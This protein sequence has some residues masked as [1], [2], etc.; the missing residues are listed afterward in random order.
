MTII[1]NKADLK[2]K[3]FMNMINEMALIKKSILFINISSSSANMT[4]DIIKKTLNADLFTVDSFCDALNASTCIQFDMILI[5][6]SKP[7]M[8]TIEFLQK[9]S[10][11][12]KKRIPVLLMN[13]EAP[14][15]LEQGY[16]N[17]SYTDVIEKPFAIDNFISKL[18]Q[19]LH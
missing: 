8:E 2:R 9:F 10:E 3:N 17:L 5:D 7:N 19:V 11:I 16:L 14:N 12:Q 18:H 6:V 15:E 1:A 4:K 13:N